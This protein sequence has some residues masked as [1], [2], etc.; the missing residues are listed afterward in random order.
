MAACGLRTWSCRRCKVQVIFVGKPCQ[1]GAGGAFCLPYQF[2]PSNQYYMQ[3]L[4]PVGVVSLVKNERD[5]VITPYGKTGFGFIILSNKRLV[6]NELQD[7]RCK[8][9]GPVFGKLSLQE[10]VSRKF[11]DNNIMGAIVIKEFLESRVPLKFSTR[12]DKRKTYEEAVLEFLKRDLST[13]EVV[14]VN[15]ERVLRFEYFVER[16]G[17]YDFDELVHEVIVCRKLI[18]NLSY[19]ENELEIMFDLGNDDLY[20]R[21]NS[22]SIDVV[23]MG[24]A[25]VQIKRNAEVVLDWLPVIKRTKEIEDNLN[26]DALHFINMCLIKFGVPTLEIIDHRNTGKWSFANGRAFY[27]ELVVNACS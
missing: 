15:G 26:Y 19:L 23:F 25:I 3:N 14:K 7:V 8:V 5:E 22:R 18:M 4:T 16:P 17:A 10:F 21:S 12:Y 1:R 9:K 20:V 11:C 13:N 6:D 24:Q 2:T 27:R